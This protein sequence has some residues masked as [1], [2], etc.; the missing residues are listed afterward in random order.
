MCT[1][2]S[3]VQNEEEAEKMQKAIDKLEAQVA[4]VNV[5]TGHCITH[6]L[7]H[8]NFKLIVIKKF[9]YIHCMW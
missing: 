4:E 5:G 9:Y 8:C 1:G 2:L 6:K 3:A 7:L